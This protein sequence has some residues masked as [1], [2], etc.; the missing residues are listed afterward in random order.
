M[1]AVVLGF[2]SKDRGE[3]AT[4]EAGGMRDFDDVEQGGEEI[5][6]GDEMLVI[7]GAGFGDAGPADHQWGAGA[8]VVELGFGEREGHAVVGEEEDDGA[9]VFAGFLE[10]AEDLAEAVV[11]AADGG[12][13]FGEL[14]ANLGVVEEEAG[15]GDF[16]GG[17]D[18]GGNVGVGFAVFGVEGFVGVGD[19]EVEA[20][21]FAGGF[22]VGDAGLGGEVVGGGVF[23][24]GLGAV[25][26]C[27]E[28]DVPGG[29]R[30]IGGGVGDFAADA[31]V[32]A[33]GFHEV[34]EVGI[35]GVFDLIKTFDA[36]GVGVATGPHDV[37]GGHAV[38]DLDEGVIEAKALGG[39]AVHIWRGLGQFAAVGADGVAAH[40]IGGD[41][42]EVGLFCG[43]EGVRQEEGGD[44]GGGE[45]HGSGET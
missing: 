24:V 29:V 8:V 11:G 27:V 31:G 1:V 16:V 35:V 21:G 20:E 38:A 37:A 40:V 45:L 12:V 7:D 36:G 43:G 17:E 13:V 2:A 34:G 42:Q 28:D 19:V 44:E 18:A 23:D 9:L 6:S 25:G 22:G 15:D 33:G 41:E 39:Q 14:G 30:V 32:V 3:G 4:V 10:G 26:E 5:D